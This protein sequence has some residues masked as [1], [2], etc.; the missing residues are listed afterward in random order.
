[1]TECECVEVGQNDA[2]GSPSHIRLEASTHCQLKCPTC[3]TATGEL[4]DHVA[5]GFL[6]FDNFRRLIDEN[7]QVREIE[8]S[9]FG[10]IFLNPHLPKIIE[11]AFEKNLLLS[12]TNGANLNTVRDTT[13]EALVKY[14]FSHI[15]C[16]IGG[17][18][19]ETY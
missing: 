4:Y 8:L 14:K 1:L 11:Y 19:Q 18:S 13:L 3:E 2:R 15:R 7:P 16:S 10:E 6:R 12:A 5:R 17:A 9:N